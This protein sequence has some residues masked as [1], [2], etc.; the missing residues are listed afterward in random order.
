MRLKSLSDGSG[1]NVGKKGVLN[2]NKLDGERRA[3][4]L[5]GASHL[6]GGSG[7]ELPKAALVLRGQ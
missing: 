4:C 1:E 2:L 3:G 5:L 7:G 6:H